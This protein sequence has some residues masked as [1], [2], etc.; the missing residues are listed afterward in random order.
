MRRE[1][2][3]KCGSW[4]RSTNREF[5]KK[6]VRGFRYK[7]RGDW[8]SFAKVKKLCFLWSCNQTCDT[9]ISQKWRIRP[10]SSAGNGLHVWQI[11]EVRVYYVWNMDIFLTKTH[12]FATGG[13]YSSPGAVWG[14]F[15]HGCARFVLR[16][17]DCWTETPADCN[18]NAWNSQDIF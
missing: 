2:K 8:F 4:M 6:N 5:V 15:Y 16:L 10:T 17:L 11:P 14:M 7:P 18:D 13:L 1:N 9:S 3:T 12:G